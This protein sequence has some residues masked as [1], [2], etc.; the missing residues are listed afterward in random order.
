M[1]LVE[2]KWQVAANDLPEG[3]KAGD[4]LLPVVAELIRNMS[5]KKDLDTAMRGVECLTGVTAIQSITLTCYA[6]RFGLIAVDSVGRYCGS[7]YA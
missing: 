5:P 3:I 1:E 7:N 2:G 4:R 6:L